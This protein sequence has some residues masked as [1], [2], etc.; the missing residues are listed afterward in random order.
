MNV[1]NFNQLPLN[2][3]GFKEVSKFPVGGTNTFVTNEYTKTL[4]KPDNT[5]A[6][7]QLFDLNWLPEGACVTFI[8]EARVISGT[9]RPEIGIDARKGNNFNTSRVIAAG[10]GSTNK[11]WTPLRVDWIVPASHQ[12]TSLTIGS[13][14]INTGVFEFRNPRINIES[15]HREFI[16][17]YAFS[18]VKTSTTEWMI[19]T[20]MV[21]T[22]LPSV[23][24]SGNSIKLDWSNVMGK[25]PLVF[26]QIDSGFPLRQ[27]IV[28]AAP[29]S[30]SSSG[31]SIRLITG[32]GAIANPIEDI[33]TLRVHVLVSF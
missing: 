21:S 27:K 6:S 22:G 17:N 30:I 12:Y 23:S 15:S 11:E 8:A 28:S 18:L 19:E 14:T 16:S 13:A 3:S 9:G 10:A 29:H 26:T 7:L 1:N 4:N 5:R 31:C 25:T 33:G 32:D 20:S 2:C 24:V